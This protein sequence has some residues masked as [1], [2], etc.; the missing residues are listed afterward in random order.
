MLCLHKI[1]Q[2]II[3]HFK[4]DDTKW[5]NIEE[6][7]LK[8]EIDLW[9][10]K[11]TRIQNEGGEIHT[12]FITSAE[13][14][15]EILYPTI[16]E[17]LFITS[18]LPVSNASAERSFSTLRR[19]TVPPATSELPLLRSHTGSTF[20]IRDEKPNRPFGRGRAWRDLHCL[21]GGE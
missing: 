12:D 11:W 15:S 21:Y 17:L 13:T 19:Y 18:C 4:F 5:M 2:N 16:R 20:E 6:T 7:E 1:V 8:T 9:K 3:N 10:L 14:C